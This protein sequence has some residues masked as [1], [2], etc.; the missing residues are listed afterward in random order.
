MTDQERIAVLE[1][2][3]RD[4]IVQCENQDPQSDFATAIINIA[5][6]ALWQGNPEF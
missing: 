2:A 3:L 4:I 6:T 5:D 1:Q